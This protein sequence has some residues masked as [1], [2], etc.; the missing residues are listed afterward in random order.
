MKKN[1]KKSLLLILLAI[2]ISASP[3]K[4]KILIIGDSISIGYFQYVKEALAEKAEV[5]HNKGNAQHTWKGLKNLIEW[6]EKEDWDIVQ[7]N[8]GLWDLCYRNPDSKEQGHRDKINGKLTTPLEIYSANL[9]SLVSLMRRST[10]AKL[11]FVTTTYVPEKEAGRFSED[12]LKYNEVAKKVM[13]KYAVTINDIYAPSID[14]HHRDG[15]GND[16]V[17]YNKEGYRELGKLIVPVL[18]EALE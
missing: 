7:F 8:W 11:I 12:P 18:E 10:D 16:D 5:V 17:H 13:Q 4:P 2:F 3:E 15:L 1:I 9:D 6:I 14:I